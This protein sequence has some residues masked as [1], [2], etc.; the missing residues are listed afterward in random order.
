MKT[1]VVA[2]IG[3]LLLLACSRQGEIT[4]VQTDNP[5]P[6][7]SRAVLQ[8]SPPTS[9]TI[10][11]TADSSPNL[12]RA[13]VD[14][15]TAGQPLTYTLTVTNYGPSHATGVVVTDTLSAGASLISATPSQGSGCYP[16]T[17]S[18]LPNTIIC[19][20]NDL[21]L[22]ASATITFLVMPIT[23]TGTLTHSAI[24]AAHE[25]DPNRLDNRFYEKTQIPPTADLALQIQAPEGATA[26]ETLIYTVTV[27]NNGWAPATGVLFTDTLPPGVTFAWSVPGQPSQPACKQSNDT[28]ICDLGGFTGKNTATIT[29]DPAAH[30]SGVST[31]SG[32]PAGVTLDLSGPTCGLVE[33]GHSLTCQLGDLDSGA[34][35]HALIA[36][37]I[38]TRM[39][40]T[41][42]H[43]AV[44]ATDQA[45]PIP[46]NNTHAAV[47]SV[48]ATS[49]ST[50]LTG[51]NLTIH[52]TV[53]GR[54][55]AGVPLT[56]TFVIT[57]RGPL[58]A[59]DVTLRLT[60]PLENLPAGVGLAS[61]TPGLPN[62][63]PSAGT[64]TCQLLHPP[65]GRPTQVTDSVTV[66]LTISS[67]ATHPIQVALDEFLPGW[68][69]CAIRQDGVHCNL[70]ELQSG[71]DT[72]VT[73]VAGVGGQATGT[74]SSTAT[75]R[76]SEPDPD[77]SDNVITTGTRVE[78]EADLEIRSV[79][80][81][82]AV[83][84]QALTYTLTVINHGLSDAMGVILTDSL[85]LGVTLNS[86]VP[87][88]GS[89]CRVV[90]DFVATPAIGT[91]PSH[92]VLCKLGQIV[93]A[94]VASVTIV[95]TPDPWTFAVTE[96]LVNSAIVSMSQFDPDKDNN[97]VQQ[98]TPISAEADLSIMNGA[99]S[100][101]TD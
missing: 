9:V 18:G 48:T 51:A 56:H 54:T 101:T 7:V 52:A 57:N 60:Q 84:G 17:A 23:S 78:L 49:S 90:K 77:P 31:A 39:T 14:S 100:Q 37:N 63:T 2:V 36:V 86:V 68:P 43:T 71:D 27:T 30:A 65:S 45:D 41:I 24:V 21:A 66:T 92:T 74:I 10:T 46:Q 26:G 58:D 20:L 4:V 99:E 75:V 22:G 55:I 3:L 50:V 97:K 1:A 96:T 98:T 79:A 38:P 34:N 62:C 83:A 93:V 40:G 12:P 91:Q 53:P 16:G 5:P 67:E 82:P 76:A 19:D 32:L 69:M 11:P 73:L 35:T 70:G 28:L 6:A 47:T 42:T 94:E 85:P 64:I 87:S 13:L 25:T 89:G 95:V 88:H 59:T 81:G 33:E 72:Q 61:I 15:V 8:E 80:S 44:V 29:L